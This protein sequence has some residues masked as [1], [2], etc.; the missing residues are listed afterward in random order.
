MNTAPDSSQNQAPIRPPVFWHLPA[1]TPIVT[2]ILIGLTVTAFLGQFISEAALGGDLLAAF[3]MKINSA[4]MQGE[5]WRLLT[6][7]FLH[8]GLAHIAFNMYALFSLGVGLEKQYGHGRF[9]MLYLLGALGGNTLS[10]LLT[11]SNSLGA[12]TAIFGLIAAEGVFIWKNRRMY[13]NPQKEL[14]NVALI[15][16]VNLFLGLGGGIDNFGHLGGLVA[17]IMFAWFAGPQWTGTIQPTGL[18]IIDQQ[19]PGRMWLVGGLVALFWCVL[20]IVKMVG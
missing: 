10:F 3:G 6:P 18:H 12:S 15:V 8:G 5:I 1:R 9:L 13:R 7:M 19:R 14:V 16:G 17:G 4:I 2:Y 11:P 20:A